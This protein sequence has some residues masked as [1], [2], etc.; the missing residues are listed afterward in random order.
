M[1]IHLN[2]AIGDTLRV[3]WGKDDPFVAGEIR[4]KVERS[5]GKL[6]QCVPYSISIEYRQ[7]NPETKWV[8]QKDLMRVKRG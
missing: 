4:V 2:F 5:N 6:S 3:P 7:V 1:N 8:H